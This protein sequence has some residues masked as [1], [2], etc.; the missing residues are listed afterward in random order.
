VRALISA[1]L[2]THSC[3]RVFVGAHLSACY[4]R[5]AFVLRSYVGSPTPIHH[6]IL[7]YTRLSHI[8]V[9]IY[10]RK[11]KNHQYHWHYAQVNTAINRYSHG[12]YTGNLRINPFFA[13]NEASPVH[14][15]DCYFLWLVVQKLQ[16]LHWLRPMFSH[17]FLRKTFNTRYGTCDRLHFHFV[18]GNLMAKISPLL[19][20]TRHLE[21]ATDHNKCN[22]SQYG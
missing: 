11:R 10:T 5:R 14:K 13:W 18:I 6:A 19:S 15:S 9:Y 2:S 12:R 1:Q 16:I 3:R 8:P 4:C 20:G 22:R 7:P 17:F 21:S